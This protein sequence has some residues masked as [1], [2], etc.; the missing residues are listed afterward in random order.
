MDGV[1]SFHVE[2]FHTVDRLSDDVQHTTLDLVARGHC[3]RCAHRDG[4]QPAL[5]SVGIVH[6]YAAHRVFAYVLLHLYNE[7]LALSAFY[8]QCLVNFRQHL[9]SILSLGVEEYVDNG[10]DDLTDASFDL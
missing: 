2:L 8:A 3:D 6:G 10:T 1:G 7:F 9:L 4:F 5:Q